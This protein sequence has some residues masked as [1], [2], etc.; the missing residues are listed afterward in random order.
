M[1]KNEITKLT[2]KV[3]DKVK[4]AKKKVVDN[5]E[6]IKFAAKHRKQM[7]YIPKVKS[8][9]HITCFVLNILLPGV[10]TIL[11]GI[12]AT[13]QKNDCWINILMGCLQLF[14]APVGVGWVWAIIWGYFIYKRGSGIM[15]Y[16]PNS[17]L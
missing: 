13:D 9:H 5:K 4:D 6:N 16:V 11:S 12:L 17:I 8:P 14:L 10:G 15:K 3:S 1:S 2:H 7:K